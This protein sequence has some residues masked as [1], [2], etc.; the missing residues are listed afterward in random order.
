MEGDGRA[1]T[2]DE[3]HEAERGTLNM[4]DGRGEIGHRMRE[5]GDRR[6]DN[7]HGRHETGDGRQET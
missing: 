2:G 5:A 6:R 3:R 1:G 7:L 4:A